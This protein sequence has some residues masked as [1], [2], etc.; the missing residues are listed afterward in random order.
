LTNCELRARFQFG[1]GNGKI[2]TT[3]AGV[4]AGGY[5]GHQVEK[6]MQQGNTYTATEQRCATV[7]DRSQ[8]PDG[9]DV[10][11][12]LKGVQRHVHLDHDP[13]TRIPVKDGQIVV[14]ELDPRAVPGPKN[15]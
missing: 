2:L 11:Y 10:V 1:G 6:K 9:F 13:G 8:V 3:V 12:V 7:Y 5:A 4:A 14:D 15:G